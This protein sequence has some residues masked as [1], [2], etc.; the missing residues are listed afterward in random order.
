[1]RPI[2]DLPVW[3]TIGA[4]TRE[5]AVSNFLARRSMLLR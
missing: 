2:F 5:R 4:G 1:M 3:T